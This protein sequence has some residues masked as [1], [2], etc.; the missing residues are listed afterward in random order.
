MQ[1]R[2]AGNPIAEI[3]QVYNTVR[4]LASNLVFLDQMVG[5]L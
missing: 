3:Q 1:I 5:P 2:D 4:D